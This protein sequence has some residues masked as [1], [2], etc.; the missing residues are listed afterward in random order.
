MCPVIATA[1]AANPIDRV[2]AAKE[3]KG[4]MYRDAL[5]VLSEALHS[6]R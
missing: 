4:Q 2:G 5:K 1:A 6:P 3:H